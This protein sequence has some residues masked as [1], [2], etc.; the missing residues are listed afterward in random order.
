ML[1]CTLCEGSKLKEIVL[2]NDRRSYFFC[3]NCNLIFV[4]PD[5]HLSIDEEK[6]R[7]SQHNN[8]IDQEGYVKFL[9]RA[10]EPTLPHLK[11]NMKGL[12][13]GCGP[14][15]TLSELLKLQG[16][17]CFDY[18]PVFEINH[19]Y[20]KYDFV[21]ATE[22]FEHFF[23]PKNDL[24]KLSSLLKKGGTLSVMTERWSSLECFKVWYYKNDPSHVSFYH[25]KTFEFIA[26][27]FNY[28]IMYQDEK[29]VIILKKRNY[30]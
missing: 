12:D 7:Y 11:E 15:P 30:R 2:K 26:D 9:N 19:P 10:I 21:F 13:Y 17:N 5:F 29:R 28:E 18:D 27:V 24:Q 25:L 23:F 8:S 14:S 1:K 6:S 20:K 3:I 22:C 4:N 16:I